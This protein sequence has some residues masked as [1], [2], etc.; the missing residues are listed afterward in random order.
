[1]PPKVKILL[2]QVQKIVNDHKKK[3]I[4]VYKELMQSK[5]GPS[6]IAKLSNEYPDFAV[7]ELLLAGE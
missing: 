2:Q 1:M 4:S 5:P 6:Q 3:A 7:R